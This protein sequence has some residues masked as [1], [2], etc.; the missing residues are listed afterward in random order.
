MFQTK[1][2]HAGECVARHMAQSAQAALL[3]TLGLLTLLGARD[4]YPLE[5]LFGLGAD[6]GVCGIE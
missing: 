3:E 4:V 2:M 1:R 5:I 6:G